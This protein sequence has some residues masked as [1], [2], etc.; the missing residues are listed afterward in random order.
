MLLY[1]LEIM[2]SKNKN[3]NKNPPFYCVNIRKLLG[4]GKKYY[5]QQE[6][7]S[8]PLA[9]STHSLPLPHSGF[10]SWTQLQIISYNSVMKFP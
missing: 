10:R 5:I 1:E 8:N 9:E 2:K 3:K 7:N 4:R 6:L